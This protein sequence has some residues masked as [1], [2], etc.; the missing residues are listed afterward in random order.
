M[1]DR[2]SR[3]QLV[4]IPTADHV[5]NHLGGTLAID[6]LPN[7][8]HA[9]GHWMA[10]TLAVDMNLLPTGGLA[11]WSRDVSQRFLVDIQIS[12]DLTMAAA[13]AAV[14]SATKKYRRL[15]HVYPDPTLGANGRPT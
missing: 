3:L 14:S 11:T 10:S 1:T 6:I 2:I 12:A 4:V 9:S 5:T 15:S 8:D 7:A 13:P